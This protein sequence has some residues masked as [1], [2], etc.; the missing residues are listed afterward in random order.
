[1]QPKITITK[2][3]AIAQLE[4]HRARIASGEVKFADLAAQESDCSR[5]ELA[6]LLISPLTCTHSAKRGGDLGLFTRDVM[7]KPFSDAAYVLWSMNAGCSS[8]VLRFALKVGQLSGVVD[9]ASGVHIILRT[10]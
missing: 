10:A 4:A 8:P 1:M 3:E 2:E 7:Q 6:V 5:Y 9:T